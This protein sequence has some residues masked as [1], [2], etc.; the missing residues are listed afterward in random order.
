[1]QEI[2]VSL[3]DELSFWKTKFA[4]E[5]NNNNNNNIKKIIKKKYKKKTKQKSAVLALA[6]GRESLNNNITPTVNA[7]FL[8][9]HQI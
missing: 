9:L 8:N 4:T 5:N 3:Q 1:M 2:L 6:S 7:V